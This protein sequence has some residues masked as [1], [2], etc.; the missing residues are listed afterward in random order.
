[1][2]LDQAFA[3]EVTTWLIGKMKGT[4]KSDRERKSAH[5]KR[6]WKYVCAMEAL[7]GFE[8]KLSNGIKNSIP[9]ISSWDSERK[10]EREREIKRYED[11]SKL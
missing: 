7:E 4:I 1:M 5:K 10:R 6:L 9:K 2:I 11:Q 8:K 3:Q